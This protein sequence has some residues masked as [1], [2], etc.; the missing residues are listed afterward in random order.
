MERIP[1]SRELTPD[2]MTSLRSVVASSFTP[3]GHISRLLQKRLIDLG[4]VQCAMGGLLPTPAGRILA[5]R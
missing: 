3:R 2:E 1:R 5:R 4:L